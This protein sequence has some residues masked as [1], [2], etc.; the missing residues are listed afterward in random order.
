M[1]VTSEQL[2]AAE[3]PRTTVVDTLIGFFET[4]EEFLQLLV[5][6]QGEPSFDVCAY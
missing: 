2:K 6:L 3:T 4:L 5:V 1:H